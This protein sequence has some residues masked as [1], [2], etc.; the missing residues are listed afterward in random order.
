MSD[1]LTVDI[2][3][4]GKEIPSCRLCRLTYLGGQHGHV[5]HEVGLGGDVG[6]L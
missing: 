5:M 3:S 1:E 6:T 2:I 4:T